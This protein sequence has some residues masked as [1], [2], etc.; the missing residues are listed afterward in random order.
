MQ[1]AKS[2]I[3]IFTYNIWSFN[4]DIA[5]TLHFPLHNVALVFT[6]EFLGMSTASGQRTDDQKIMNT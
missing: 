5:N 6:E 3:L 1:N 2:H 4:Q